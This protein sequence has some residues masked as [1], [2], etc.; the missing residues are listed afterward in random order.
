[1]PISLPYNGQVSGC[2]HSRIGS[3]IKVTQVDG[4]RWVEIRLVCSA[5][6]EPFCFDGIKPGTH[7][8]WPTTSPDGVVARLPIRVASGTP[9]RIKCGSCERLLFGRSD[10][11]TVL[12]R[13][14]PIAA[15]ECGPVH[16]IRY[17]D[18]VVVYVGDGKVW[19][20]GEG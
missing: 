1:M 3:E 8:D 13:E 11:G 2:P 20:D 14:V 7:T 4:K 5:C 9:G 19:G 17:R 10:D 15:I 18:D 12:H 6:R 16:T